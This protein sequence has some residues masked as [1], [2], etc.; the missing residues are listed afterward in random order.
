MG[1]LARKRCSLSLVFLDPA[2]AMKT[3]NGVSGAGGGAIELVAMN[4][5]IVVG[6]T[7]ALAKAERDWMKNGLII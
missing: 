5:S 3:N 7:S 1:H 6:K 4:G 2:G